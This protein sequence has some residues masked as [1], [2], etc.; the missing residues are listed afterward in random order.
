MTNALTGLN[1]VINSI[2]NIINYGTISSAGS[3]TVTVGGAIHNLAGL[4][5]VSPVMS[6]MQNLNLQ[7]S[8]I[9]NQGAILA[10]GNMGV[11]STVLANQTQATMS[12]LQ[13]M[14]LQTGGVLNNG[15]IVSRLGNAM[16]QTDE[17]INH[18][19]LKAVLGNLSIGSL[20]SE[21]LSIENASGV[22]SGGGLVSILSPGHG[23]LRVDG[24]V[25][26]AS[27]A[28][29][30][31]SGGDLSLSVAD[32]DGALDIKAC[33]A[34]VRITNGKG[35]LQLRSLDITGDPNLVFSGSGPF[36]S[37]GFASVGGFVDIDT[38]FCSK[39]RSVPGLYICGCPWHTW[40]CYPQCSRR[41]HCERS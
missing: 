1:L 37:A 4:S 33:T 32:I 23:L 10:G 16:V 27:T 9:V 20:N 36:V 39:R 22:L 40:R 3:L 38:S 8:S 2:A 6:A 34:D 14:V 26:A 25:L 31:N 13:N 7:A 12:S 29:E 28:V 21:N 17:L 24:G 5:G 11:Q 30:I 18:G 19:T 35:G 15:S 41:H